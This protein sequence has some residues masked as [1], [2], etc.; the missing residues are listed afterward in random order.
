[1]LA[2]RRKP[3]VFVSHASCDKWVAEQIARR[4]SG[5]GIRTFL[6]E[7]NFDLGDPDFEGRLREA[8]EQCSELVA[9]L[10]PEALERPYVWI[11]IGS[12]WFQRKRVSAILYRV[13]V[14]DLRERNGVPNLLLKSNLIDINDTDRFLKQLRTRLAK[15]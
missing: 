13:T 3:G 8:L 6:S 1:L 9:L 12:A 2:Q 11:E 5:F 10:T 4:V 15:R 14:K 7:S